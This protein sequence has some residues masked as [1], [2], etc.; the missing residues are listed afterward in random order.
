MAKNNLAKEWVWSWWLYAGLIACDERQ[1]CA[2]VS[3]VNW[4]GGCGWQAEWGRGRIDGKLLMAG[5]LNCD[6]SVSLLTTRPYLARHRPPWQ[7]LRSSSRHTLSLVLT[8][9]NPS[10]TSANNIKYQNNGVLHWCG[11]CQGKFQNQRAQSEVAVCWYLRRYIFLAT[12][13]LICF[14]CKLHHKSS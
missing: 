8:T 4:R 12:N 7:P 14:V 9:M 11:K 1:L 3:G 13:M 2:Q 6:S 10:T 5:W